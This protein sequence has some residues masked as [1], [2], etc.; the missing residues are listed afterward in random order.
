M[1]D[2]YHKRIYLFGLALGVGCILLLLFILLLI[3][4]YKRTGSA[5]K[6]EQ[7]KKE[8]HTSFDVI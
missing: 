5:V 2:A 3:C 7:K 8:T 6:K 1:V 4:I